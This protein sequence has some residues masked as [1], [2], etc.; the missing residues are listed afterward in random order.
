METSDISKSKGSRVL[1]K[2]S[3]GH[4]LMMVLIIKLKLYLIISKPP[5]NVTPEFHARVFHN[6]IFH[7]ITK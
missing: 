1:I 2:H 7:F 3:Y 6:F 5:I 4:D